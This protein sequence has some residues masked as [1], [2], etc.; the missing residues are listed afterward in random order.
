MTIL[1]PAH[2][3]MLLTNLVNEISILTSSMVLSDMIYAVVT[4]RI[5]SIQQR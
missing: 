1:I 4:K 2:N 3:V 5:L